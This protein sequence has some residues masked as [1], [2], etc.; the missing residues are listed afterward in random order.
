MNY[1]I[2]RLGI[3]LSEIGTGKVATAENIT[4]GSIPREDLARAIV[5]ALDEENTYKRALI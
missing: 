3:L 5:A 4:Y 1:T 2:I